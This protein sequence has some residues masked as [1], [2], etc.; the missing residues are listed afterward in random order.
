M[1]SGDLVK[2]IRSAL[3]GLEIGD[4]VTGHRFP[5]G[6]VEQ[7]QVEVKYGLHCQRD[8]QRKKDGNIDGEEPIQTEPRRPGNGVH[9]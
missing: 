7:G 6:S 9:D 2:R 1:K 3:E 4:S 5:S 8:A